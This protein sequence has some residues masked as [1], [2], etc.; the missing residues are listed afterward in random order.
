M[1]Q[2]PLTIDE[3]ATPVAT[4]FL[5]SPIPSQSAPAVL[6]TNLTSLTPIVCDERAI[7]RLLELILVKSGLTLQEVARR[8]GVTPNS[9]RQYIQGRRCKPSLIWVIRFS[10]ACGSHLVLETPLRGRP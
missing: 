6:R 7:P 10:E 2:E 5:P 9:V 4:S 8:L 3:L 1:T